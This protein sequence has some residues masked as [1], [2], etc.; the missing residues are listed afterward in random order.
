MGTPNKSPRSPPSESALLPEFFALGD[1]IFN[2]VAKLIDA[3]FS[4]I[5]G[6]L[7]PEKNFRPPLQAAAGIIREGGKA[8]TF[9]EVTAAAP[10]TGVGGGGGGANASPLPSSSLPP[11]SRKEGKGKKGG[12]RPPRPPRSLVPRRPRDPL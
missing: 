8:K 2:R 4:A 1:A 10:K 6:K 11:A 3:R 5:E 9:A 12:P 7:L